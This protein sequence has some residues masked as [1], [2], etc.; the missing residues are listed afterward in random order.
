MSDKIKTASQYFEL[1]KK[2]EINSLLEKEK[3]LKKYKIATYSL[4]GAVVI[5]VISNVSTFYARKIDPVL[6]KVNQNSGYTQVINPLTNKN[7]NPNDQMNKYWL[8][9]FVKAREGY[10]WNQVQLNYN[11]IQLM[12]NTNSQVFNSYSSF[13]HSKKLSPL[14]L[15]QNNDLI[16]T[17]ING[18]VLLNK[19]T[20]QVRFTNTVYNNL[21]VPDSNYQ[22]AQFIATI[23]FNYN[24]SK[25][26]TFKSSTLN[27]LGFT[28]TSYSVSSL[29]N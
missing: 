24:P 19:N 25:I 15:F 20:A 27:P 1:L 23:T 16:K 18:I 22:P 6:I 4:I 10:S 2:F 21:S 14:N 13:I 8:S 28:V 26:N 12:T 29:N 17:V 5:L 9:M 3:E 11:L 7:V